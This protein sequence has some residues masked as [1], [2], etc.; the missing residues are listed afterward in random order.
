MQTQLLEN[1]I[2]KFLF[3]QEDGG[4]LKMDLAKVTEKDRAISKT[5]ITKILGPVT[6]NDV[7]KFSARDYG[8][9]HIEF[10]RTSGRIKVGDKKISSYDETQIIDDAVNYL[11]I[12]QG[13]LI[14]TLK[15]PDFVWFL[16]PEPYSK[17]D[18]KEEK[19]RAKY[20][21]I[22]TYA[23]KNLFGKVPR[24]NTGSG[25]LKILSRGATVFLFN[26]VSVNDWVFRKS[27]TPM[28]TGD[29]QSGEVIETLNDMPRLQLTYGLTYNKNTSS[30]NWLY[31]YFDKS[32]AKGLEIEDIRNTARQSGFGCELQ[33]VIKQFQEEQ[34]IP[35]TGN[36]DE[37]TWT[38]VYRLKKLEYKIKNINALKSKY[39]TCKIEN[40][41]LQDIKY[42]AGG[43]FTTENTKEKNIEF[44]KIEIL[45]NKYLIQKSKIPDFKGLLEQPW[46]KD[47]KQD[48]DTN[49]GIYT[50]AVQGVVGAIRLLL[51]QDTKNIKIDSTF[52]NDL[53]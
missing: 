15:T 40:L 53:R 9:I 21:V 31:T 29:E 12:S 6:R 17:T 1:I 14:S 27:D 19:F 41:D 33:S 16:T 49:P 18:N 51:D 44:Q 5:N 45:M 30:L 10:I 3:E 48:L 20:S 25:F 22:A 28:T 43:L 4:K 11:N 7:D 38:T 32:I 46:Y 23:R 37:Q 34:N 52:V 47:F 8:T 26:D 50:I 39:N 36:W 35:V 42:P 24:G 13:T 2:R